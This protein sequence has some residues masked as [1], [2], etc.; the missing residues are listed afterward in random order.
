MAVARN[1]SNVTSCAVP[2]VEAPGSGSTSATRSLHVRAS[3]GDVEAMAVNACVPRSACDS[4][5][6]RGAVGNA[7][8]VQ[9]RASSA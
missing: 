6:C 2:R 3:I 8:I 9:P 1:P 4:A 5:V 7:A